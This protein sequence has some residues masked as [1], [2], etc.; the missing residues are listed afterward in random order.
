AETELCRAR[1]DSRPSSERDRPLRTRAQAVATDCLGGMR[2]SPGTSAR[3]ADETPE[4]R[5]ESTCESWS[6]RRPLPRPL[7]EAYTRARFVRGSTQRATT[8]A[9]SQP[10]T[11]GK[12]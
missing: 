7:W 3:P 5:R 1:P 12:L 4:V 6:V 8:P 2:S 10:S 9:R 11:L